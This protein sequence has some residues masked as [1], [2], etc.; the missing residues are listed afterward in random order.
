M[1]I[2]PVDDVDAEMQKPIV[3]PLLAVETLDDED[4][5]PNVVGD[6]LEPR[7]V[8]GR[9]F[10]R[11]GREQLD[12]R[13]ERTFGRQERTRGRVRIS[14]AVVLVDAARIFFPENLVHERHVLVELVDVDRAVQDRV[15]EALADLG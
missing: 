10:R 6:A 13:T 2:D 15:D 9:E 8:L 3:S 4:D 12:D 5:R 1:T 14:H 7:V 11:V